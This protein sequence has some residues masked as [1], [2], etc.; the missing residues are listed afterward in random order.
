MSGKNDDALLAKTSFWYTIGNI[1]SRA[2]V[3]LATP[4][5]I[6]FLTPTE[7]GL[8]S[9]FA[10]WMSMLTIVTTMNLQ[11]SIFKGRYEHEDNQGGFLKAIY[12]VIVFV[13]SVLL[14]FTLIFFNWIKSLSGL[15]KLEFVVLFVY[16]FTYSAF[17]I[18][19]G[20]FRAAFEVKKYLLATSIHIV[21][22]VALSLLL[23]NLFPENRL[24]ALILG[25]VIPAFIMGTIF[26][27]LIFKADGKIKYSYL[28]ENAKL[29]IPMIPHLLG[30]TALNKLD[31]IMITQMIGPA[32]NAYYSVAGNV[33]SIIA[34]I[35]NSIT[36][37][38]VP[39]LTKALEAKKRD[40]E[41]IKRNSFMYTLIFSYFVLAVMALAPEIIFV[42]GGRE[43]A[44]SLIALIPL[45]IGSLFQFIYTMYVNLEF[46]SRRTG[47]T[48]IATGFVAL[49]N[50]LLNYIFIPKYGFVAAAITTAFSY[51]LLYVIHYLIVKKIGMADVFDTRKIIILIPIMIILSLVMWLLYKVRVVRYIVILI[52]AIISFI[53]LY[54]IRDKWIPFFKGGKK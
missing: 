49:V 51:F 46:Y 27:I 31:R 24:L 48:G 12:L 26:I 45:L 21:S 17:H 14:L 40:I 25:Q 4:I 39:W 19:T 37:A 54:K 6:R 38:F 11:A 13:I 33:N 29:G 9:N 3:F 15:T 20:K 41:A 32:E 28:R 8:Y 52:C 16:L 36:N 10:A 47:A 7:Y 50:V 53:F 43:Y 34:V 1:L 5:Y 22:T 23:M 35:S 44:I 42:F 30:I 2:I 18:Y